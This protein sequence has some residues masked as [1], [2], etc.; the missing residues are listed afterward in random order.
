MK[1][2]DSAYYILALSGIAIGA[3]LVAKAFK[4]A[5]AAAAQKPKKKLLPS[6]ATT[7]ET[8]SESPGKVTTII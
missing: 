8:F 3:Y 4:D 6:P 1:S 2:S 5:K 7:P